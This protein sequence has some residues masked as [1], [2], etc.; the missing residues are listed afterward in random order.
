MRLKQL[1]CLGSAESLTGVPKDEIL[2]KLSDNHIKIYMPDVLQ[3][4]MPEWAFYFDNGLWHVGLADKPRSTKSQKTPNGFQYYR[5]VLSHSGHGFDSRWLCQYFGPAETDALRGAQDVAVIS[6][7]IGADM[8][9]ENFSQEI[10]DDLS[11]KTVRAKLEHIKRRRG[12]LHEEDVFGHE[13]LDE[14]VEWLTSYLKEGS[15]PGGTR[16]FDD[17]SDNAAS[18]VSGAMKRT[19]DK[20]EDLGYPEIAAFLKK[21]VSGGKTVVYEPPEDEP[22]WILPAPQE[23][24]E[25]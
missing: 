3:D 2:H 18:N 22:R 24:H 9:P 21:Y 10:N 17:A 8:A 16:T 15:Y 4:E 19:R 25:K 1:A 7:E 14:E 11:Q 12:E 5:Y 6:E 13:A 23:I 20:I